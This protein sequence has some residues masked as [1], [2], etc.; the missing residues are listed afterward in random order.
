MQKRLAKILNKI[1][2]LLMSVSFFGGFL[3]L[4]PFLIAIAIGGEWAERIAVFLH[5]DFYPWVI[6]TGSI[7]V[8]IGLLS[9]YLEKKEGL[10]V[11]SVGKK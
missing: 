5:K 8:V 9:M 7:S 10:S 11:N 1:Y 2:G 4:I 6:I 3:P